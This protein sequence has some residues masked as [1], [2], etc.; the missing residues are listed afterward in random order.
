MTNF[1]NWFCHRKCT[2]AAAYDLS[3]HVLQRI[4][5]HNSD[6]RNMQIFYYAVANSLLRAY[7]SAFSFKHLKE[8]MLICNL[9]HFPEKVTCSY[10]RYVILF[11]SLSMLIFVG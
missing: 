1:T 8:F 6:I 7:Y 5:L 11:R 2:V 4:I 3:V 10:I 9:V